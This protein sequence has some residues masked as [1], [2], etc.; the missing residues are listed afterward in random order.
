MY[1]Y[2]SNPDTLMEQAGWENVV[3]ALLQQ[4]TVS[5]WQEFKWFQKVCKLS[6]KKNAKKQKGKPNLGLVTGLN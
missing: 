3:Y 5:G 2:N 4:E 1:Q 6:E